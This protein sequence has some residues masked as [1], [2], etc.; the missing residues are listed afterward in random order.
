MDYFV[1][2]PSNCMLRVVWSSWGNAIYD[3]HLLGSLNLCPWWYAEESFN[4]RLSR[5]E[6][7]DDRRIA[8]LLSGSVVDDV[9]MIRV[10][11]GRL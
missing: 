8:P 4:K 2:R 6:P 1:A 5:C 7:P 11:S 3:H 9:D 10:D